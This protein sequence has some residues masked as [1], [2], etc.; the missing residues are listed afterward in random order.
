[1]Q[2]FE[3]KYLKEIKEI[4]AEFLYTLSGTDE[5]ELHIRMDKVLIKLL[6]DLGYEEIVK[7]YKKAEKHF[8]YA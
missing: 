1:M 4:E 7:E 5:E 2:V 3:E 6:R 8:W